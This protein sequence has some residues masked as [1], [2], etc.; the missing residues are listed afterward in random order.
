MRAWEYLFGKKSLPLYKL[1]FAAAAF[2][3][4]LWGV[5][6][7]LRVSD[8]FNG[9]MVLPNLLGLVVLSETV[10]RLTPKIKKN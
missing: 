10:I 5:E 7:V 9:C 3:G 2:P 6:T 1:L 4:A 8:V